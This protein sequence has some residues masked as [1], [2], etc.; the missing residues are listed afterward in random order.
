MSEI[1]SLF[2]R[3]TEMDHT[4]GGFTYEIN[5][6]QDS[7]LV[8]RI[9]EFNGAHEFGFDL[10]SAFF[11]IQWHAEH[12]KHAGTTAPVADLIFDD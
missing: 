11:D 2:N 7:L 12:V 3:G 9:T 6:M 5:N 1:E 4:R 8:L 10:E